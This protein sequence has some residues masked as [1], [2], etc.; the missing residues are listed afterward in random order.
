MYNDAILSL[1]LPVNARVLLFR[2]SGYDFR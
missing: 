2:T 1:S